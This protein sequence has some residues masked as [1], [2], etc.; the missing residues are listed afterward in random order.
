MGKESQEPLLNLEPQP[1]FLNAKTSSEHRWKWRQMLRYFGACIA[2][3]FILGYLAWFN[4]DS[5]HHSTKSIKE[6]IQQKMY[7]SHPT[8]TPPS[9]LNKTL[10]QVKD[11]ALHP[12]APTPF[13]TLPPA[14]TNEYIAV[15]LGVRDPDPDI[16][17]WFTH[18]YHH[19]G[20]RRFY[21]IDDG[22]EPPLTN[23]KNLYDV[24][25]SAITFDYISR[26]D[27]PIDIQKYMFM[28]RCTKPYR[29]KHTWMGYIDAD[30][31]IE[32]RD[33]D[34]K[35]T[36]DTLVQYL[37]GWE[38]NETIGAVAAQWLT[39][40]SNGLEHRPKKSTRKSFTRCVNNDLDGENK[41]VKMF[42]KLALV[43]NID[44]VHHIGTGNGTMQV[45][46]H[47]EAAGPFKY[48]IT[49]DYWALHHYGVKSK[50]QFNEKHNRNAALDWPTADDLF[51]RVNRVN[52]YECPVLASYVP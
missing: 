45:G 32:M 20:I 21:V 23:R 22:S 39:H 35:K 2:L 41:H 8:I 18:Y 52:S 19:H 4:S 10:S 9:R 42:A 25:S 27:R 33:P 15:C 17:E 7:H 11:D 24:P 26:K 31:F 5:I 43:D 1:T 44:S 38:K 13:P 29:G 12:P 30:E 46:E 50:D 48:P 49:H 3:S 6:V 37:K 16:S 28:E 34:P 51:D 47:G 14:D 36:P 40:N